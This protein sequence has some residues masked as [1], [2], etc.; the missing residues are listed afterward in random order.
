MKRDKLVALYRHL[1]VTGNPD[2]INLD[3]FKLTTD[4]KKGATIFNEKW[5]RR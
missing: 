5:F 3:R 4:P 2:L 1:N